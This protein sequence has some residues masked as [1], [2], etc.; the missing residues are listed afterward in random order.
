MGFLCD[1]EQTRCEWKSE[2][3]SKTRNMLMW[4][5]I[6]TM[7]FVMLAMTQST[8]TQKPGTEISF[9]E[10]VAAAEAGEIKQAKIALCSGRHSKAPLRSGCA[11]KL[12]RN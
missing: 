1:K 7:L 6:I 12:R 10:M 9:S 5:V 4:A 2:M 8:M 11:D 3:N